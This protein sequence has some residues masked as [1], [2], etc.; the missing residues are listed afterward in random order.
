MFP[1]FNTQNTHF[2]YIDELS[3][4]YGPF[5]Y[6]LDS[7]KN[8]IVVIY[9]NKYSASIIV[10]LNNQLEIR[11]N[12][13]E[14]SRSQ[15]PNFENNFENIYLYAVITIQLIL[16]KVN[17]PPEV[18]I[19]NFIS[20]SN[21]EYQNI[22]P[23]TDLTWEMIINGMFN[24]KWGC[25]DCEL[26]SAFAVY[27]DRYENYD[28]VNEFRKIENSEKIRQNEIENENE[29][30]MEIEDE[31][32]EN[33]IQNINQFN[34]IFNPHS[35]SNY[36]DELIKLAINF[37][38]RE[39]ILFMK[40]I[41]GCRKY[42]AQHDLKTH[43]DFKELTLPKINVLPDV[44][45]DC[46]DTI[47]PI[48]ALLIQY[49]RKNMVYSIYDID[50]KMSKE[51]IKIDANYVNDYCFE[52]I[53]NDN[54]FLYKYGKIINL[55]ENSYIDVGIINFNQFKYIILNYYIT[56][57]TRL[58]K[59]SAMNYTAWELL[60]NQ[61]KNIRKTNYELLHEYINLCL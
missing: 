3:K 32:S 46:N 25:G 20:F 56:C 31:D 5:S 7:M 27:M 43:F 9:K 48:H 12:K 19:S 40:F 60:A 28:I 29:N 8:E 30:E 54:Q 6:Y 11:I 49:N 23:Q 61:L 2:K 53:V 36:R 42:N 21:L 14:G 50:Q 37:K 47:S 13:S 15:A 26:N 16:N 59:E 24:L 39:Y 34:P 57:Q 44:E 45:F 55:T 58:K 38:I 4:K 10:N 33:S 1:S 51:C 22:E 35:I 17:T 52:I 18:L 41:V